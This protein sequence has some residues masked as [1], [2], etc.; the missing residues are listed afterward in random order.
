MFSMSSKFSPLTET[1]SLTP[2]SSAASD[3]DKIT[4]FITGLLL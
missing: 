3:F 2:F 4:A 1:V